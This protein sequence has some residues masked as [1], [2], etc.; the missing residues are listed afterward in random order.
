[1]PDRLSPSAVAD[2]PSPSVPARRFAI[3]TPYYSRTGDEGRA[4]GLRTYSHLVA[5]A[6]VSRGW[7]VDALCIDPDAKAQPRELGVEAIP[8]HLPQLPWRLGRFEPLIGGLVLL[9]AVWR[10]DRRHRYDAIECIH[11]DG[12]GWAL[13]IVFGRRFYLRMHTSGRQHAGFSDKTLAPNERAR[14][15]WDRITARRAAHLVTHSRVHAEAMAVE[16]GLPIDRIDVLFHATLAAPREVDLH[17]ADR[18]LFVG[19]M[20]RR[21][22]IDTFIQASA[23]ARA[24]GLPGRWTAI[25]RDFE[26]W[27]EFARRE[28]SDATLVGPVDAAA[29]ASYWVETRW[30]V[31]PSRYESFGLVV[32]EAMARGIPVIA[33]RGGALPEVVGDA[34]LLVDVEQPDQIVAA[35]DRLVNEPGL[36]A[37]LRDASYQRYHQEFAV[38]RFA[39][40]LERLLTEQDRGRRG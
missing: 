14:V 4:G 24:R 28:G 25:G 2:N 33:A 39:E 21:K 31:V 40:R 15:R 10:L 35:I 3:I 13:A 19:T 26:Q 22:G 11:A 32:I 23:R 18:V 16:N 37:H 6:L 12:I 7:L 1:M 30:V 38:E 9:R 29:L 17:R 8:I 5:E 34:G 20:E 27:Q 36:E